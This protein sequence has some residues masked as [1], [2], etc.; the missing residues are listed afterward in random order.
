MRK[1]GVFVLLIVLAC[2]FI[3]SGHAQNP[4]GQVITGGNVTAGGGSVFF[5]LAQAT[6]LT[7]TAAGAVAPSP[8]NRFKVVDQG[9]CTMAAGTCA[10]QSLASTY[11]VA[12]NCLA[13]YNGTGTL[14]GILKAP[15]TTTTVTPASSVGTVGGWLLL[16]YV[17]AKKA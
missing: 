8:L 9:T 2:V 3:F 16:H 15:S 6:G 5:D 12:P 14:T 1:F 10:A 11:A 4:A 13:T 7:R 17:T